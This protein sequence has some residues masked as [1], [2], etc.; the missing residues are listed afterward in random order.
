ME[1]LC[2]IDGSAAQVHGWRG[3][4]RGA[5]S[6]GGAQKHCALAVE[7]GQDGII[8]NIGNIY[9]CLLL[10]PEERLFI[11]YCKIMLNTRLDWSIAGVWTIVYKCISIE[12][13][14]A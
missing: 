4:E 8:L 3:G 10:M 12:L 13:W 5:G 6:R 9:Y 7:S 14:I 1:D 11:V 2:I